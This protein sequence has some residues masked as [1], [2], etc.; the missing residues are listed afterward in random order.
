MAFINP[1]WVAEQ[2][3]LSVD[4]LMYPKDTNPWTY[5]N[6]T[7]ILTGQHHTEVRVEHETKQEKQHA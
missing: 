3:D 1:V 2:R 4:D 6:Q 7:G 5:L